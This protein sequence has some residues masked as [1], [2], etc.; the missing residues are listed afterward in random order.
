MIDE[1]PVFSYILGDNHPHVLAMPF[2]VLAVGMA[3]NLL[4]AVLAAKPVAEVGAVLDAAS[5]RSRGSR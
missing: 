1:F 3:L 5:K 4:L 2:A